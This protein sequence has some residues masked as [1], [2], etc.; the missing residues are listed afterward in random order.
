[1]YFT[2]QRETR[3]ENKPTPK[4]TKGLIGPSLNKDRTYILELEAYYYT[5]EGISIAPMTLVCLILHIFLESVLVCTLRQTAGY[6][7]I[8]RNDLHGAALR[9]L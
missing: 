2:Q 7:I 4:L 1:M 3:A 6:L 8:Q 5:D 9:M